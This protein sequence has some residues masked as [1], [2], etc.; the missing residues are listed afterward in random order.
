[1]HLTWEEPQ[2]CGSGIEKRKRAVASLE[3]SRRDWY[4]TNLMTMSKQGVKHSRS[5]SHQ[6]VMSVCKT[7]KPELFSKE[8]LNPL[9]NKC[10]V[11]D[12]ETL[13][14]LKLLGLRSQ[15]IPSL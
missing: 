13:T 8:L 15:H 12:D 6:Y 9:L 3:R 11:G 2:P 7:K 5:V 1:M 14:L 4:N 10:H